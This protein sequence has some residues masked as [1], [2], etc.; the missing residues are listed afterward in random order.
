MGC[1]SLGHDPSSS[2]ND[3]TSSDDD[4]NRVSFGVSSCLLHLTAKARATGSGAA[5]APAGN[6]VVAVPSLSSSAP[7]SVG[8]RPPID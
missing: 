2:D 3:P 6:R 4:P 8:Q 7:N 1:M 5:G